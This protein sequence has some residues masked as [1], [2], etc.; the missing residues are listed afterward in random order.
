MGALAP[1]SIS[2]V[3]AAGDAPDWT[4]AI[5]RLIG[6]GVLGASVTPLL[7]AI[8]AK[9]PLTGAHARRHLWVQMDATVA[10]AAFLIVLSCFLAAWL[11]DRQ[12]LPPQ[13]E[14]GRQL[15]ADL[16]LLVL[17]ISLLLAA[18]QTVPIIVRPARDS[19]AEWPDH[20]TIGERGRAVIVPV[21]AIQWIETQGN[22]QAVHAES[23]VHLYPG[24]VSGHR[25]QARP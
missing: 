2:H 7:L 8:A 5:V 14:I 12:L 23:G 15:F 17:C 4:R 18:I 3:L 24:D 25:A 6:A 11:L 19:G 9:A 10:L 1:G 16:L 20:L 21:G 13:G 22:Y